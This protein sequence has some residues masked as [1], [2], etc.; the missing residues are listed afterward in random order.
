M[1]PFKY[2]WYLQHFTPPPGTTNG[3]GRNLKGEFNININT[4]HNIFFDTGSYNRQSYLRALFTKNDQ[5]YDNN[6]KNETGS[7]VEIGYG[8]QS[9]DSIWELNTYHT[10]WANRLFSLTNQ[11][12]WLND[13]SHYRKPEP[14][15]HQT[16]PPQ[17]IELEIS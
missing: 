13:Y 5:F 14:Q 10:I 12:F 15:K 3:G 16:V 2:P 9:E 1:T 8:L 11:N 4:Q 6:M 7:S 17:E